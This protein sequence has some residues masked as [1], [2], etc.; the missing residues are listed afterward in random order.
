[1]VGAAIQGSQ[2]DDVTSVAAGGQQAGRQRSHA[3]RERDTVLRA[4]ELG[5]S[6]LEAPH[7]RVAKARVD[8]VSRL[9]LARRQGVERG[10]GL[11]EIRRGVRAREVDRWC[12][13]TESA[14]VVTPYMNGNCIQLH[15]D[16]VAV[17]SLTSIATPSAAAW[18]QSSPYGSA[19]IRA[20]TSM[21]SAPLRSRCPR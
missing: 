14:E 7:G 19:L 5:E 20:R 13:H 9:G 11:I 10:D 4:F 17:R 2:C 3:R 21:R 6:P 15:T 12:V 8:G 1:M 16:I 18:R